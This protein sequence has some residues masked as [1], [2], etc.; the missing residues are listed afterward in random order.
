MM[1]IRRLGHGLLAALPSCAIV[2]SAFTSQG[3]AHQSTDEYGNIKFIVG[4][5]LG[6]NIE[7]PVQCPIIM[8]VRCVKCMQR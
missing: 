1:L 2:R 8:D 7:M 4:E 6:L 5:F 3:S